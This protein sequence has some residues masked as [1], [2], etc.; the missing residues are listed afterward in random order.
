MISSA[1]ATIKAINIDAQR[2]THQPR[3]PTHDAGFILG[4]GRK[5]P[6]GGA[7]FCNFRGPFFKNGGPRKGYPKGTRTSL[8]TLF[9][10]KSMSNQTVM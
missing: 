4:I 9:G 6:R 5:G 2:P 3:R 1:F 10:Q 7:P 8:Y